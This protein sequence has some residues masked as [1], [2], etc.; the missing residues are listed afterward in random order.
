MTENIKKISISTLP[1]RLGQ[2]LKLAEMAQDGLEAK[3]RIQNREVCVNGQVETR[4]GKQLANGD[5]VSLDR[6]TCMVYLEGKQP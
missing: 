1:I 5:L 4:R 6:S 2:F 3:L